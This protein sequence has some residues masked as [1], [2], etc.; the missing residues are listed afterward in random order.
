MKNKLKKWLLLLIWML[1]IFM[2]SNQA[3]SGS[4]THSMVEQVLPNIKYT[5]LIDI[6][7][8]TIRKLAHL[9]EYFILTHLT[10]SL[11][12]EYT[13]R[14][15]IILAISIIFCFIYAM[16]DEF[17][18]SLIPGRTSLFRDVIIDTIGGFIALITYKL[19]HKIKK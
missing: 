4:V 6:I 7:N 15:K 16:A 12:K 14:E 9:T 8:F 3:N 5:S 1:I 18:Q 2:F 13:T 17:H 11:L 10:I 19:F